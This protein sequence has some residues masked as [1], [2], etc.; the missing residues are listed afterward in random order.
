MN[1][2]YVRIQAI[3][4]NVDFSFDPD[5]FGSVVFNPL[6]WVL[7]N[8]GVAVSLIGRTFKMMNVIDMPS[9]RYMSFASGHRTI[10]IEI[11]TKTKRR[12]KK[13]RNENQILEYCA[14]AQSANGHSD[15]SSTSIL[16]WKI[17]SI[18]VLIYLNIKKSKHI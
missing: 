4:S 7:F 11:K 5:Q 13:E 14:H 2:R 8:A 9:E 12:R 16:Q 10:G 17:H 15:W 3:N 6:L 18:Y 1:N